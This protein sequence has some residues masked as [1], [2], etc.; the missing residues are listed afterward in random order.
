MKVKKRLIKI[1]IAIIMITMIWLMPKSYGAVASKPATVTDGS[2]VLVSKS[3]SDFYSLCQNM[4]NNGE[5]LYGSSVKPH[6]ATNKDWGAVS[7][8]SNSSYGTNTEG[9][10]AG[11]LITIS[12]VQYYST[13]GNASGVMNWGSNKYKTLYTQTSGILKAYMDLSNKTNNN[14]TELVT[15]AD[16]N[17]KY[18][19]VIDTNDSGFNEETNGMA[20]SEINNFL[21]V[22]TKSV[23]NGTA[24]S[25]SVRTGLFGYAIG[26]KFG[27]DPGVGFATEGKV[28]KYATFRP[29]VWN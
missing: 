16:N 19:E 6:L 17:S 5:S 4:K 12:G 27:N 18:V 13:T 11:K 3:V 21:F 1:L 20:M 25:I 23:S 24:S 8:L 15:A 10:N 26:V 7:Y 14:L 29:V 28:H 22:S 9:K 2:N